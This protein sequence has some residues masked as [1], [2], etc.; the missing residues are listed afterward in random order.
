[1]N[2]GDLIAAIAKDADITKSEAAAAVDSLVNH[3]EKSLKKGDKVTLVGFGSFSV[4]KRAGRTGR[5]PKTGAPIKIPA[6]K[7]AKF[8]PGKALKDAINRR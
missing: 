4:S 7:V 2:K 8:T 3:I 6:K 1:M 5:N